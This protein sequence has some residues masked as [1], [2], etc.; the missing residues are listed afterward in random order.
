MNSKRP[1]LL[2]IHS[3]QHS[4]RVLGCYHDPLVQTPHLD[5]LAARGTVFESA[6]CPSP[7]CTPSRMSMLTGRYPFENEVWTNNQVL[8]SG[9]PT[10]AHAMGAAGY[11]PVLIG[12]MHALGTDQLHGYVERPVGDH[13]SNFPGAGW[14]PKD[15]WRSVVNSGSGQSAYQVHDEVV[16]AEVV[17]FLNRLG[18]Q[19]RAG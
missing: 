6:Y 13:S 7:V 12:R 8:D 2:Y 19:K 9:I 18:V 16:T 5:H 11:R 15:L 10:M 17:A 1:N 3:D 4:P 14:A